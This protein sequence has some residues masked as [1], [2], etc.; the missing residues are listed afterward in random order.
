MAESSR[1]KT[2]AERVFE[3]LRHQTKALSAYQ[4]LDD[5]RDQGD[6]GDD[7]LSRP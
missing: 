3:H 4:I 1:R 5:L 7:R 2:H 6:G